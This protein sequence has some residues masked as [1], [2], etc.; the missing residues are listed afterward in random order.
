MWSLALSGGVVVLG[1]LAALVGGSQASNVATLIMFPGIMCE[2]YFS[3]NPH[4]GSGTFIGAAA[5]I[6][7]SVIFWAIPAFVVLTIGHAAKRTK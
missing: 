2:M 6:L 3:R 1:G 5:L 4:A 7:G